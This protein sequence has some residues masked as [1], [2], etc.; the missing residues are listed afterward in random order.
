MIIIIIL[1]L[2]AIMS[3][4][5]L[6]QSCFHSFLLHPMMPSLRVEEAGEQQKQL[7]LSLSFPSSSLM[8]VT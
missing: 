8:T 2:A 7:P 3:G 4:S 6:T 5:C 1:F